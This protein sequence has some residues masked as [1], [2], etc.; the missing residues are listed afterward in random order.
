MLTSDK[1]RNVHEVAVIAETVYVSDGSLEFVDTNVEAR[2]KEHLSL[3]APDPISLI[4]KNGIN[5]AIRRK[6]IKSIIG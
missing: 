6:V 4:T 1:L 3:R 2:R 5:P